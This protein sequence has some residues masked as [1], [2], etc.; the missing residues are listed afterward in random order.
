MSLVPSKW[1]LICLTSFSPD[2]NVDQIMKALA[3]FVTAIVTT[4]WATA[5]QA[6]PP[7]GPTTGSVSASNNTNEPANYVI[8]V[9]WK[10]TKMGSTFVQVMTAD[11]PFNLDALEHNTMKINGP[12]IPTT[13]KLSGDLAVLTP[14]KGRLKLYIGRTVPYM[15][16]STKGPSGSAPSTYQ[17]LSVGLDSTFIVT[18]GKPLVIQ[19]D[20]NGQISILVKRDEG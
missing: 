2:W 4:L 12:D 16:G 5:G 15:T 18:F 8:S 1:H 6:A 9:Q 20:E 17:Q 14:E 3:A 11:G 10:D 7:A 19:G 13:L